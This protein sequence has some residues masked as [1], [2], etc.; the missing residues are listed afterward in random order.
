MQPAHCVLLF[1]VLAGNSALFRF[2]R[3][4]ML[5]FQSPVL[6]CSWF[7]RALPIPQYFYVQN[8]ICS[9]FDIL[10]PLIQTKA[11]QVYM[12]FYQNKHLLSLSLSPTL[13][14][15]CVAARCTQL[16]ITSGSGTAYLKVDGSCS[17]S[18]C[19]ATIVRCSYQYS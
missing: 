11:L 8:N 7:V 10:W 9:T 3:S 2:L 14:S 15:S 16:V 4:Y 18:L 19:S 13:T 1:L 17:K 12:W 5:L 6:M